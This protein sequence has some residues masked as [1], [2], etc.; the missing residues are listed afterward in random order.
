MNITKLAKENNLNID[1]RMFRMA[2]DQSPFSVVITD[3][4]GIIVYINKAFVK[5]SGFDFSEVIGN[6]PRAIYSGVHDK[7]F[8]NELW[9]TIKSKNIWKGEICNKNKSGKLFWEEVTIYPILDSKNIITGYLSFKVDISEAKSLNDK[10]KESLNNIEKLNNYN[11]ALSKKMTLDSINKVVLEELKNIVDCS[12]ST[13]QMFYNDHFEVVRCLGFKNK[14]DVLGLKF[15]LDEG[16]IQKKVYDTKK[17]V[18]IND[19]KILN[20]FVDA[21]KEHTIKSCLIVPLIYD[22]NIFGEISIDRNTDI[23]FSKND[24]VLVNNIA[25]TTSNAIYKLKIM[26]ELENKKI[27]AISLAKSREEFL[28]V[29]SHEIKTPLNGIVGMSELLR[30]TDLTTKQLNYLNKLKVSSNFLANI[31]NDLLDM[32]KLESNKMI[33]NNSKFNLYNLVSE[34]ENIYFTKKIMGEIEPIIYIEEGIPFNLIGDELKIKQILLNFI[35][36]AI[37]FTKTGK[38]ELIIRKLKESKKR[39]NLRF[40]VID[41]GIGIDLN[42]QEFLFKSFSQENYSIQRKYGG[43]GL[44]LMISKKICNLMDSDIKVKSTLGVGSD[45]YFD[46]SLIKINDKVIENIIDNKLFRKK[47]LINN[48]QITQMRLLH[49]YLSSLKGLHIEYLDDFKDGKYD[50]VIILT[51]LRDYD[52]KIMN[53]SNSICFSND[54]LDLEK[55]NYIVNPIYSKKIINS[56]NSFVN[57]KKSKASPQASNKKTKV[58]TSKFIVKDIDE[59]NELVAKLYQYIDE[60]S[61]KEAMIQISKMQAKF[62]VNLTETNILEEQKEIV[63]LKNAIASYNFVGAKKIL[64]KI[65]ELYFYGKN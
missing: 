49:K 38:I 20:K 5:I 32:S 40:S 11:L 8:Y 48:F 59:F 50:E 16:S 29:M 57:R 34:I 35:S 47:I 51:N 3:I 26:K 63:E 22:N 24:M 9:D 1:N 27:E 28:R 7:A 45:F 25:F 55:C 18:L 62:C 14:D 13:I 60:S 58:K 19:I 46:I 15:Y 52:D 56:L 37:K 30:N 42:N 44:G 33:I 6:T 41:T 39:V 21:S 31:I 4:E 10:L 65:L 23:G 61:P 36:N 53:E 43:T 12:S 64:N 54:I 2:F 17:P